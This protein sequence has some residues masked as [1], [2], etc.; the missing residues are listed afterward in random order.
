[1][2]LSQQAAPPQ[3]MCCILSSGGFGVLACGERAAIMR[4][5]LLYPAASFH[6]TARKFKSWGSF[7]R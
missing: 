6:K 4:V 5:F 7:T 1:M 3:G 2:L